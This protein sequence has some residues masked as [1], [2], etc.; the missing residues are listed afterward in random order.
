MKS[1]YWDGLASSFEREV[2]NPFESDMHG[3][4]LSSIKKVSSKSKNV[5]DIGCG[6]G[7]L[8]PTLALNFKSVTALDISSACL[9]IAQRRNQKLH[10]VKFLQQDL[11]KSLSVSEQFDVGVCLNVALTPTYDTRME[12]LRNLTELIR[13]NGRLVLLVPAL[14]SAL[15]SA[16]RLV[17]WNLEDSKNYKQ[18]AAAASAELGFT[19]RSIRDGVV[20]AGGTATK[21]YLREE[22]ELLLESLGHRISSIKKVEYPWS[23]EFAKPPAGM[24]APYPWD[25]L[26]ISS[27]VSN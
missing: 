12:L 27:P 16:H 20:D 19:A 4:I 11:T 18:A 23:T 2:F 7:S 25:W 10:N 1:D 22:L 13:A 15:F 24:K 26:V 9:E 17:L 6:V 8:I 5:A 14:E 21:H 3:T